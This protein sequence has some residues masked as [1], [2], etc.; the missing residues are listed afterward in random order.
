[1]YKTY[2]RLFTIILFIISLTSNVIITSVKS[3]FMVCSSSSEWF[4][5]INCS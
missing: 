2:T 4:Y 3:S 1:M 5:C